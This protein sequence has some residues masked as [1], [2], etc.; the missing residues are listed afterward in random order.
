M[1]LIFISIFLFST[2]TTFSQNFCATF[3]EFSQKSAERYFDNQIKKGHKKEKITFSTKRIVG[4]TLIYYVQDSVECFSIKMTFKSKYQSNTK[5]F[6]NYQ[7]IL[8]ECPR[9]AE[10]HLKE[11]IK[12]NNFRQKSENSYLSSFLYSTELTIQYDSINMNPK[13][14][15]YRPVVLPK[16]EYK[17]LYKTLKKKKAA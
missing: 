16:S 9:C 14:L 15:I 2:L 17:E 13:K 12:I 4:D 8:F 1:K 5:K 7:E 10:Y 6:C 3:I 11:I